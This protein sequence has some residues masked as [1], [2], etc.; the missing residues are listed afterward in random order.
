MNKKPYI[1][2]EIKSEI[3]DPEALAN[4]GSPGNPGL[5]GAPGVGGGGGCNKGGCNPGWE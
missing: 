1:K 2:P 3:V 4:F 5:P